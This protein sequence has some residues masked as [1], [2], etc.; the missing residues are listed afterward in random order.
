MVTNKTL[1]LNVTHVPANVILILLKILK[2]M[3]F[4]KQWNPRIWLELLNTSKYFK[5]P[6]S[7]SSISVVRKGVG[8]YIS[9]VP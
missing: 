5:Y 7:H 9:L 6:K 2:C 8:V 1:L 4:I 3:H